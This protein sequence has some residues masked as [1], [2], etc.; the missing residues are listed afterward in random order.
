MFSKTN[1]LNLLVGKDIGDPM[2]LFAGRSR[3][4]S[5]VPDD[6]DEERKLMRTAHKKFK[7]DFIAAVRKYLEL[8]TEQTK[9]AP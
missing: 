5:K 2:F 8:D 4:A 3:D 1:H 9:R 6:D 7:D